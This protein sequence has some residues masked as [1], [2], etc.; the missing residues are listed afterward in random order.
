MTAYVEGYAIAFPFSVNSGGSISYA[1]EDAVIWEDRV[2][3]VLLT[4]LTERV[5]RPD[6]G[7]RL[8]ALSFEPEGS[9]A[10]LAQ[11]ICSTA[12]VLF[13]PQLTLL[14]V[15]AKMNEVTQ[16][17]DVSVSYQTPAGYVETISAKTVTLNRYGE[18]IQGA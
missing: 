15:S 18:I 12:F 8:A 6:F 10:V 17:V 7:T 3:C 9:V 11:Q 2:R 1:T 14:S 13:L 4:N 5:M 16:G